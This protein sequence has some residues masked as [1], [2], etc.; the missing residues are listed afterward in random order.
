M[1]ATGQD[2][3]VYAGD[4]FDVVVTVKDANDA[5][6]D[7]TGFTIDWSVNGIVD[8]SVGSGIT[9]TDPVNGVFTIAIV[10]TDTAGKHGT[11]PHAARCTD[12]VGKKSVVM[13][14]NISIRQTVAGI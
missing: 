9:M 5:L 14:G 10:P 12:L 6:L 8:K 13:E 1:T 7:I 2:F 4:D 11:Y 3:S